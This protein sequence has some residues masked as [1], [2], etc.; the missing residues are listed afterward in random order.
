MQVEEFLQACDEQL[1]P[2]LRA[3]GEQEERAGLERLV[4]EVIRPEA[5]EVVFHELRSWSNL[6]HA[7]H[8]AAADDFR[9]LGAEVDAQMALR[10]DKLQKNVQRALK[11]DAGE[12]DDRPIRQLSSYVRSVARNA[13]HERRRQQRPGRKALADALRYAL[14]HTPGLAL[15]QVNGL[16]G[17][18]ELH[19]G[20]QEWLG[21]TAD[22]LDDR[23]EALR[24]DLTDV[25]PR[26]A[27][28]WLFDHLAAPVRFEM[29]VDLLAS[30]SDVEA[31]YATVPLENAETIASVGIS[32]TRTASLIE[33]L[34]DIWNQVRL[35]APPQP[36]ILLLQLPDSYARNMLLE[37]VTHEIAPEDELATAIGLTIDQLQALYPRLPL[38]DHE[39]A[40]ELGL[41]RAKIRSIRQSAR[42]RLKRL[43]DGD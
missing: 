1:R 15:W 31:R 14:S 18:P 7:E 28:S 42:R 33:L 43:A 34:K 3:Q 19:C 40:Q 39:I 26:E 38:S 41:E 23:R 32:G 9:E 29:V 36:A 4:R 11:G 21:L 35:L 5:E 30:A 20:R 17:F 12:V 10:L 25:P 37:F 6:T 8:R 22:S 24:R 16:D 27:L 2:Y 13:C